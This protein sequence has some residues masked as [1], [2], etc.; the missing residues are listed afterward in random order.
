MYIFSD[1]DLFHQAM[2]HSSATNDRASSNE[3][4]E[5]LG[6]AI[7]GMVITEALYHRFPE[8]L[9]GELSEMKS[10]TVSRAHCAQVAIRNDL[11][12]HLVV[13][14]GMKE[15]PNSVLAGVTEALI[16]AI[17]LDSGYHAAKLFILTNFLYE[18]VNQVNYKSELQILAQSRYR[19]T[20]IYK[21]LQEIG[22]DH[23]KSFLVSVNIGNAIG[24]GRT[25]QAAEQQAARNA[26][27][28]Q[29]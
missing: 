8:S 1:P 26:L 18:E 12:C 9:E 25:K 21:V 11:T 3:R 5:L 6:D 27:I 22:P 23:N 14:K 7:L 28:L 19:V 2:L 15:I 10:S 17:Y 16:G 24:Q 4:L 20:P 13:G 29:S